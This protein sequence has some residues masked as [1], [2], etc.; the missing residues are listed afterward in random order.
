MGQ[1]MG[2][3][4]VPFPVFDWLDGA[5]RGVLPPLAAIVFW[6]VLGAIV[7]MEEG[8]VK[9][10][11][12]FSG[13]GSTQVYREYTASLFVSFEAD[14]WIEP[15]SNVRAGI[16]VA[17]E[18]PRR[19]ESDVIAEAS[20]SRHKDGGCEKAPHESHRRPASSRDVRLATSGQRRTPCLRVRPWP[21]QRTSPRVRNLGLEDRRCRRRSR[22]HRRVARRSA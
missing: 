17:R 14:V 9:V 22:R 1:D 3:F 18:R 16:F 19:G 11:G 2:I 21:L 15:G 5:L 8:A 20:V 12:M 4:D 10:E 6:G 13:P 7:S